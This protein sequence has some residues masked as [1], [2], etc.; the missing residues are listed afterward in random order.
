MI[1]R[2]KDSVFSKKSKLDIKDLHL[3]QLIEDL[4][5][6]WGFKRSLRCFLKSVGNRS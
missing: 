4:Q 1:Y 3:L 2:D 5:V 6:L